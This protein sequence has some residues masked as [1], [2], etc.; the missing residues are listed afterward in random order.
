MQATVRPG[1]SRPSSSLLFGYRHRS[2]H[3]S[4]V[5]YDSPEPSEFECVHNAG[6]YSSSREVG[7]RQRTTAT[8]LPF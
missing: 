5:Q 7:L 6:S 2:C 3:A 1:R 4:T 8:T